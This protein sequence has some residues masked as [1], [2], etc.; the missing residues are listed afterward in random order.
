MGVQG[1]RPPRGSR[2]AGMCAPRVCAPR[3]SRAPPA[4]FTPRCVCSCAPVSFHPIFPLPSLRPWVWSLC[5][6]YRPS[7]NVLEI[8]NFLVSVSQIILRALFLTTSRKNQPRREPPA[9]RIRLYYCLCEGGA[10]RGEGSEPT[11]ARG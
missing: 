7:S 10:T 8:L 6:P 3:R 1:P 9:V 4:L 11:D 5:P 2:R